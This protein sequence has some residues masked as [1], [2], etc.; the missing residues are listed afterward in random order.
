MLWSCSPN[1]PA[2]SKMLVGGVS[3]KETW[4]MRVW[5]RE[6]GGNR[7]ELVVETDDLGDAQPQFDKKYQ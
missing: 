6:R 1:V 4:R 3:A 2:R 7:L 5:V